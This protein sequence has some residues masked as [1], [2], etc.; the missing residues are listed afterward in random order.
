[1]ATHFMTFY[2]RTTK[3]LMSAIKTHLIYVGEEGEGQKL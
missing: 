1:M 3:N 2:S